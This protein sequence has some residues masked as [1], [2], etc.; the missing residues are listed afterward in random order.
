M[1]I[2]QIVGFGF[3]ATFLAI[4]LKEQKANFAF[5]ITLAAGAILF[6]FLSEKIGEILSM[7]QKLA[8]NAGLNMIYVGTILKI[9][10]IAY[11]AEFGSHIIRDAGQSAIAQKVELAGKVLILVLAIPI[12]TVIIETV[13]AMIP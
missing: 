5:L 8:D 11:I 6:I 3:I 12:M 10:G 2:I 9:I 1:E 13:I 4:V 7:L